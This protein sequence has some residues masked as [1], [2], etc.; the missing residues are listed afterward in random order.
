MI[1]PEQVFPFPEVLNEDEKETLQML[2]IN[3]LTEYYNIF[4]QQTKVFF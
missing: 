4:F 2:V 3:S 1:E